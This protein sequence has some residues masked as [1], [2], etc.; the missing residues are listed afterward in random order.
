[1]SPVRQKQVRALFDLHGTGSRLLLKTDVVMKKVKLCIVGNF[2]LISGGYS[3][4]F[5]K[6]SPLW[7]PGILKIKG[8]KKSFIFLTSN[9]IFMK[10]EHSK[11]KYFRDG[12]FFFL[13]VLVQLSS[14]PAFHL[15]VDFQ[16]THRAT[17]HLKY[18]KTD[19]KTRKPDKRLQKFSW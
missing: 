5:K 1:M 4:S 13:L 16:C 15:S 19:C 2:L 8:K 6:Y 9:S 11:N 7:R 18:A 12:Y 10:E 3:N 14:V 17:T